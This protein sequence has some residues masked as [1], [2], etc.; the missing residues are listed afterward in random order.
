VNNIK[1][2]FQPRFTV[3]RD[4]IGNLIAGEQQILNRWAEYF[5]ELLSSKTTQRM[6]TEIVYFGPELHIPVPMVLDRRLVWLW[7]GMLMPIGMLC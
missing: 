6:N 3:C 5:E 4:K 2:V 7:W 1:R